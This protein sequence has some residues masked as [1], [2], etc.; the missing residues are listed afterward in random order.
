MAA[1]GPRHDLVAAQQLL[2]LFEFLKVVDGPNL[3][4]YFSR[5]T[6]KTDAMRVLALIWPR[7]Q[8][9]LRLLLTTEAHVD[10][11]HLRFH[12]CNRRSRSRLGPIPCLV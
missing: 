1:L 5:V 2:L 12:V 3:L 7:E 11:V 9:D 6:I 8:K 10:L 4:R